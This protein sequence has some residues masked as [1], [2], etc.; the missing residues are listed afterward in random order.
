MGLCDPF[1]PSSSSWDPHSCT[2]NAHPVPRLFAGC[3][4]GSWAKNLTSRFTGLRFL[5]F[6]NIFQRLFCFNR[7]LQAC[8]NAHIYMQSNETFI[9]CWV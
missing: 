3:G 1:N 6:L 9:F 7:S 4:S 2:G 8:D 5:N